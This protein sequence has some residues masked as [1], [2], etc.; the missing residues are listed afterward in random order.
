V[1]LKVLAW[2]WAYLRNDSGT[3]PQSCCDDAKGFPGSPGR[4]RANGHRG[5]GD[6][7][8]NA[9]KAIDDDTLA[10]S[11]TGAN[12]QLISRHALDSDRPYR[13]SVVGV[14][15]QYRHPP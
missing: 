8:T 9:F 15:H 12:Q 1:S 2:S 5:N 4:V 13:N 14:D 6:A 11:Q 3:N 10:G 7:R